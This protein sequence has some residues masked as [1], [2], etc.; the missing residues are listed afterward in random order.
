MLHYLKAKP[1]RKLATPDIF[2]KDAES[3]NLSFSEVSQNEASSP[4]HFRS[5]S[6]LGMYSQAQLVDAAPNISIMPPKTTQ[7]KTQFMEEPVLGVDAYPPRPYTS[8]GT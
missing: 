2:M 4:K 1:K 8:I 6:Q 7:I 3:I 5:Y